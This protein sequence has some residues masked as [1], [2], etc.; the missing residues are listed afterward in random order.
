[1]AHQPASP[2]ADVTGRQVLAVFTQTIA[3]SPRNRRG[4]GQVS[5]LLLAPGQFGSANLAVTWVEAEPG[6]QQPV[7]AHPGR[8]QVYVIVAGRGQMIVGDE[9][10]EVQAGTMVFVPPGTGH[11]I[12]N[13][14]PGTL[15]YVSATSPPF[16]MPDGQFAYQPAGNS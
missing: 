15:V 2:R 9:E 5:Y 8:E 10:Q 13:P 1:M 3:N 11:A 14:G 12:R 16:A 7:H 6:S 4:G